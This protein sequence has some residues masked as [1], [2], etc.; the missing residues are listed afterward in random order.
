MHAMH[1]VARQLRRPSLLTLGTLF[2]TL[3]H[4]N[5]RLE[6]RQL[7]HASIGKSGGVPT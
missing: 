2:A 5:E 1:T 3:Q 6:Q 7:S 4:W